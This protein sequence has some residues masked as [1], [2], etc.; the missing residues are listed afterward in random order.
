M[1]Q[2]EINN[3]NRMY[4]HVLPHICLTKRGASELTRALVCNLNLKKSR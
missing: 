2:M 4:I 1:Y 3:F